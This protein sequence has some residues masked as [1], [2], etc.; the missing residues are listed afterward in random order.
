MK[1][2]LFANIY[3]KAIELA[4]TYLYNICNFLQVLFT[5]Y[6]RKSSIVDKKISKECSE[7]LDKL[8]T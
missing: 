4:S 3:F 5:H 2:Y 6:V 8:G 7:K 1:T